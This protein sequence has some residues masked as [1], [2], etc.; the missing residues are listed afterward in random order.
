MSEKAKYWV[1]VLY[2]ENM[3]DN[4]QDQIDDLLELPFCYC[5][6]DKDKLS[7]HVENRKVHVHIMLIFNNTTTYNHA[8]S[9][10]D[11]LSAPDRKAINKCEKILDV[12][13]MYD[14][15]IHDTD[16]CRKKN[17]HLYDRS[18]RVSG[19]NFDIGALEQLSSIDKERMLNELAQDIVDNEFCNFMSFYKHILSN[20]DTV[21]LSLIRSNSGFF[22]RLIKG[23][24]HIQLDILNRNDV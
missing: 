1:G 12:K 19:N 7:D 16:S 22:D 13:R 17:K 8:F 24:Y 2:T 9:I 11:K 10:F 3:V 15:L 21:Y 18:E 20:Y 5:I 23:N 4:W 14:Y 6:H